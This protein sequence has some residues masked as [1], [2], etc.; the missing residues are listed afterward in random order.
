MRFEQLKPI[1][2]LIDYSSAGALIYSGILGIA[3]YFDDINI[4][5]GVYMAAAGGLIWA[6]ARSFVHVRESISKTRKAAHDLKM[7]KRRETAE[8]ERMEMEIRIEASKRLFSSP[9][10]LEKKEYEIATQT[11]DK[12]R[13]EMEALIEGQLRKNDLRAKK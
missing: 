7:Q 9:A 1:V 12:Y 10:I 2:N 4:N 13:A 11:F 3:Q 6:F 5:P 8:I